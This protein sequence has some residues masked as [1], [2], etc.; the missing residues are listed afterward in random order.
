[1]FF[2]V[3][4]QA[5]T[6]AR[7]ATPQLPSNSERFIAASPAHAP[8]E[9]SRMRRPASG[10]VTRSFA[11]AGTHAR[12]SPHPAPS[13][14]APILT[15]RPT[16]HFEQHHAVTPPRVDSTAFRPGWRV[17]TRLDALFERGL[18]EREAYE[19]ARQWRR[20]A[21]ATRPLPAMRWNQ[22]VDVTATIAADASAVHRLATATRLRQAAEALGPLRTKI[23]ERLLLDGIHPATAA[24]PA[25]V[26]L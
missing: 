16:P 17:A 14:P 12:P 11:A 2:W 22:K 25:R 6:A 3:L 1:L 20:W 21:E 13:S 18:I 9:A 26:G 4:A 8:G 19:V 5:D 24:L 23:L 10:I 7:T 15:A